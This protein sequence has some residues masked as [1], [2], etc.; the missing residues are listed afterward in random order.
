M[1]KIKTGIVVSNKMQ[2][3][4][5]VEI[6]EKIPH[7]LYKKL[8]T[9]SKRI[10]AR[11]DVGCQI[12]QTVKILETKPLAKSVYFKVLEVINVKA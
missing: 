3:T 11:D 9:R 2:K 7:P 5:V 4:V 1:S 8:I 10:K 6:K 12:G